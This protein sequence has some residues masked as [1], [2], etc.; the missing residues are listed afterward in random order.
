M[1]P[2]LGGLGREGV[3][4]ILGTFS[5]GPMSFFRLSSTGYIGHWLTPLC[6][7]P[8]LEELLSEPI[9][10]A[11]MDADGVDPDELRGILGWTS[12]QLRSRSNGSDAQRK[13]VERLLRRQN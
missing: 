11:L 8:T 13:H 6:G 4:T 12:V 3:K 2:A 9:I 10:K 1:T 7:E 5:G